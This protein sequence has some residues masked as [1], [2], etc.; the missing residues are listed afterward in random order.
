VVSFKMKIAQVAP[1]Y[2]AV[3]PLL[4]G[5]T[6]RVVAHL[7]DALVSLGHEVTLFASAEARTA[8]ALVAVRD[9]AIRLDPAPLKSDLA[10]HLSMLD[11]V[12]RRSAEFD[13]IHFHT[14]LIQFPLFESCADRTLTTLHGRLDLKD[15]PEAYRRWRAFPLVSISDDQRRPLPFAN[16][17]ATVHHGLKAD[18]YRPS[19]AG[20]GYLAFLGRISPE[21][22]PDRAI[23]IAQRLDMPLKIAAKVDP[24]DRAY[25]HAEIEPLI[26]AAP[27]VEFIGEIGDGQKSEF[28]GG[29]HALLFPIAWPEPFGLVMIE[30]M[31]CG[32][33][34]VA[35]DCGSVRE[36]VE[37]GFTGFIVQDEAGAAE[38]V[39]RAMLLDRARIRQRFE[40]RFSATA[41]AGRYLE[42][43][44]R[45]A[46]PGIPEAPLAATA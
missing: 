10:A 27:N 22:R 45:L 44:A 43:Y 25:F 26:A 18:L 31:A 24:V 6:E 1:L 5:G 32:T 17:L 19:A 16:W 40:D 15:L 13:V 30:A 23:A 20:Q 8:A 37:D 35:Y 46:H 36:V 4:Y 11:E 7:C 21:K 41:M 9:Q 38:A 34:V 2:E 3:P 42:L 28:L 12:R 39:R 29:A 14:D 33:P